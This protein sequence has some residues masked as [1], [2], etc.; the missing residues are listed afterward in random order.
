MEQCTFGLQREYQH[1]GEGEVDEALEKMGVPFHKQG[2]L[3]DLGERVLMAEERRTVCL[4]H[5]IHLGSMIL[6]IVRANAGE[7][8]RY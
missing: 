3:F 8:K 2:F 5:D 1:A 4:S 7:R 6:A